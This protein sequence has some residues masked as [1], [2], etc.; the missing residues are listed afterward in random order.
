LAS[1]FWVN[2]ATIESLGV[3]SSVR[4]GVLVR[5][6]GPPGPGPPDPRPGPPA[7]GALPYVLVEVEPD[8]PLSAALAVNV[9]ASTPPA[10]APAASM[11]PACSRFMAMEPP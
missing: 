11:A 10:T 9:A 1:A 7:C 8:E 5:A 3:D 6:P 2:V 4:A